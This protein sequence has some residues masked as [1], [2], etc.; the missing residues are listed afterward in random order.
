M[1]GRE[2]EASPPYLVQTTAWGAR[3]DHIVTCPAWRNMKVTRV[4]YKTRRYLSVNYEIMKQNWTSTFGNMWEL[5]S[6]IILWLLKWMY[7]TWFRFPQQL[8]CD[9]WCLAQI[10]YFVHFAIC[11]QYLQRR[12][13]FLSP[14]KGIM[15]FT[16]GFIRLDLIKLTSWQV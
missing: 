12:A 16:V 13:S 10:V 8:P 15:M 1:L 2:C 14:M 7:S 3:V 5:N 9:W 11:R 6:S 4:K